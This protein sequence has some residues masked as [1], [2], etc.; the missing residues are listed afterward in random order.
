M[1]NADCAIRLMK[2]LWK[3][4][5]SNSRNMPKPTMTTGS[6]QAPVMYIPMSCPSS[7]NVLEA[8]VYN[9]KKPSPMPV[10]SQTCLVVNGSIYHL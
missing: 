6:F 7:D 8:Q 2:R 1:A 3:V 10:V 5:R 9:R 4:T